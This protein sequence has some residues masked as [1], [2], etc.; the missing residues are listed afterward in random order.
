VIEEMKRTKKRGKLSFIVAFAFCLVCLLLASNFSSAYATPASNNITLPD[1]AR[2][3]IA[4]ALGPNASSTKIAEVENHWL[5]QMI[6]KQEQIASTNGAV[7]NFKP[8]DTRSGSYMSQYLDYEVFGGGVVYNPTYIVGLIDGLFTRCYTPYNGGGASVVGQLSYAY[9][10]GHVYVYAKLG[11]TGTGKNGNYFIVY[12]SNYPDAP[13]EY[14]VE[15]VIG[16]AP[17]TL[18]YASYVYIGWT[19]RTYSYAC[20]GAV[21]MGGN[22]TY[23]DV[24]GDIVWFTNA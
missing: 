14:W 11:P 20:V 3:L 23:N 8:S 2:K 17:I 6:L 12:G 7:L 21:A 5:N 18:T 9:S 16:W 19:P 24:M 4:E 22:C 13:W 10:T 1:W 15:N